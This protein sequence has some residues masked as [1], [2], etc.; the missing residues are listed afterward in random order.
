MI[1]RLYAFLPAM[2]VFIL[3]A[4]AATPALGQTE[5]EYTYDANGNLISDGHQCF[6]YNDANQLAAV[7]DCVTNQ[8]VAEYVYDHAGRRAIEKHY[9]DGQLAETVYT[10][11]QHTETA[12]AADGSREDTTYHRVNDE[13]VARANPDGTITYYH[14][15]HLGST[16]LLT[17]ESGALVEE[18]RYYPFG[19]LREGGALSRFLYTGQEADAET[20]L[21]YYGARF[22][23]PALRR[24]VQPDS[25]LP[26]PYDPQQLNR[27]SYVAN[28]PL[29]YTDPSGNF[30]IDW[31]S[32]K[33]VTT[34][35][36]N[37]AREGFK[38]VESYGRLL[39][40]SCNY[41]AE[42]MKRVSPGFE[43]S[44]LGSWERIVGFGNRNSESVEALAGA[45]DSLPVFGDI[46][47]D[48]V[49]MFFGQMEIKEFKTR[50]THNSIW[51][52]LS[53]SPGT[54]ALDPLFNLASDSTQNA[55]LLLSGGITHNQYRNE[56][57]ASYINVIADKLTGKALNKVGF[58]THM[59]RANVGSEKWF[60]GPSENYRRGAWFIQNVVYPSLAEWALNPD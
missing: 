52:L 10:V 9:R 57:V 32:I 18:T 5:T 39:C 43:A 28:N 15:D 50:Q 45:F 17:D 33:S 51:S 35:V 2:L 37:R 48:N 12:V 13:L 27:Y 3:L 42:D 31:D 23:N 22:Y 11:G 40:G 53:L 24:F 59:A 25:L 60:F 1:R 54:F 21:Y 6:A 55:H 58:K 4:N 29:K 14:G 56:M 26:D 30:R 16:S 44:Y 7:R 46:Y 20:G 34:Q 8:L 49:R 47:G 38:T 36:L 41:R 19:A